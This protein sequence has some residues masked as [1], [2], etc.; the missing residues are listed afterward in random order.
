MKDDLGAKLPL[1]PGHRQR[2]R[3]DVGRRPRL[4]GPADH[5]AVEEIQHDGQAQPAFAR[6]D[7]RDVP[8]HTRFGA[9]GTKSRAS[10][11]EAI[12]S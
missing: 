11:S 3:H 5:L 12:G 10:R 6:V 1:E 8:V 2:I 9:R 4:A 7:V